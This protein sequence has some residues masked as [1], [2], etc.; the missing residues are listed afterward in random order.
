MSI[1]VIKT[2]SISY[3]IVL[4]GPDCNSRSNPEKDAC[5]YLWLPIYIYIYLENYDCV[6]FVHI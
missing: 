1:N 3:S 5:M 6:F 4:S 2:P